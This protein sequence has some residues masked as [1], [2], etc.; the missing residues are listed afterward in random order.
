MACAICRSGRKVLLHIELGY[1]ESYT[2]WMDFIRGMI[3]RGLD[4]PVLIATDGAPGLIRAVEEIWPKSLRQRCLAH[5]VQNVVDKVP[6]NARAEVKAAI[7]S[8]YRAANR[9]IAE[10]VAAD[11]LERY[12]G[13]YP[14]A[15][16]SFTDDVEACWAHLRCPTIHH[17]RIHTTNLFERAFGDQKRRT[18][19]IPRF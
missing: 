1:R 3:K 4:T 12:Q 2:A 9:K 5:K 15:K 14:S 11:L 16:K 10:V 17:K 8:A 13:L 18:K 6:E 7:N 19:V